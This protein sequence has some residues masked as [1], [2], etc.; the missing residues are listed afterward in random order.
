MKVS[1]YVNRGAFKLL[2]CSPIAKV[3]LY[4]LTIYSWPLLS[5]M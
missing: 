5:E 4:Y 1:A 3:V 2:V